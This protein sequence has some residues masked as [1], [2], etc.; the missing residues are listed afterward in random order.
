MNKCN[1]KKKTHLKRNPKLIY[2][3]RIILF[4]RGFLI[5]SLF[6]FCAVEHR[7]YICDSYD[8]LNLIIFQVLF[9]NF[10]KEI[11]RE[12]NSVEDWKDANKIVI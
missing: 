2:S 9:Q 6:L 11:K 3:C 5:I 8:K 10:N 1:N 12:K 7:K 4:R